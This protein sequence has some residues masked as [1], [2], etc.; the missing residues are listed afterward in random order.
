MHLKTR[1]AA[2]AAAATLATAG[3][4]AVPPAQAAVVTPQHKTRYCKYTNSQPLLGYGSVGKAVKQAQCEINTTILTHHVAKDGIF[5]SKTKAA[6]KK[7]QKCA[8]IHVDGIIGPHTWKVLNRY[9]DSS[10]WLH[11]KH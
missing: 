2:V 3:A 7:V 11:C 5:G 6:T 4:I 9:S 10:K 8:G 1:A